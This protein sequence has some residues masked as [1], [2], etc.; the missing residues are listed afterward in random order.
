[1]WRAFLPPPP[2]TMPPHLL[3][4]GHTVDAQLLSGHARPGC[5]A[6]GWRQATSAADMV[7]GGARGE[8]GCTAGEHSCD[9]KARLVDGTR[10]TRPSGRRDRR[11]PVRGHW[12]AG[13]AR[14]CGRQAAWAH[15]VAIAKKISLCEQRTDEEDKVVGCA[16]C[17]R[18]CG[19]CGWRE[20]RWKTKISEKQEKK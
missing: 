13:D 7:R 1:V 2:R 5:A 3:L 15:R 8:G 19:G 14:A 17:V 10:S 12:A 6:E 20:N 9:G 11:A 4:H 18:G 16:L